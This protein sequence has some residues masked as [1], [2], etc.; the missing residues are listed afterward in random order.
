M[1]RKRSA[2]TL[3]ATVKLEPEVHEWLVLVAEKYNVT[4]SG[5]I[6]QLVEA[7]EPGIIDLHKKINAVKEEEFKR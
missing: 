3:K 7:C 6:A 5:A 2:S 1:K 4:L